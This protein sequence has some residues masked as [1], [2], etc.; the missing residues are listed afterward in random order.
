MAVDHYA[1]DGR[2]LLYERKDG[3]SVMGSEEDVLD[4]LSGH[5]VTKR[6]P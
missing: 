6:D 2:P 4:I 1:L 3:R 5:D